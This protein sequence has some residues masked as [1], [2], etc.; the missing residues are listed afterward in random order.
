MNPKELKIEY[1]KSGGPGGQHKNKRNMAVRVTHLST[2]LTAVCQEHRLQSLNKEIAIARLM[3]RL[4]QKTA[5]KKKRIPTRVPL[6]ARERVLQ[7]KRGR[8][9]MKAARREKF[10]GSE[11]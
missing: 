7:W 1:F 3:A 11:Q 10:S 8:S 9:H 6:G 2:G 4:A 5:K